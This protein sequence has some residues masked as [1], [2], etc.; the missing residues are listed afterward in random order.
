[1]VMVSKHWTEAHIPYRKTQKMVVASKKIG[2][3]ISAEK[4]KY[5]VISR[6]QHTGQNYNIYR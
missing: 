3:E 6:D 5:M 4:T 1:M 2:L